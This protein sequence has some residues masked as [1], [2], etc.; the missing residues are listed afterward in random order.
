M[1]MYLELSRPKG[2]VSRWKKVYDRLQLLNNN[3]PM[4]CPKGT[5]SVSDQYLNEP[6]RKEIKEFLKRE[7]VVLLG[8]NASM[9]QEEKKRRWMLPLDVLATPEKKKEVTMHLLA[10]FRKH[11][12]VKAREFDA[13]EELMPARTDIL[14]SHTKNVLVRV[15]ETTACHSYH[16]TSSGLRVASVPTLLQFFLAILYAPKEFLE[17][18]PEQR[19]L[20]AAE[21]LVNS[22]NSSKRKRKAFFP[23]DCLGKQPTMISMRAE[24]SELYKKLSENKNSREFIEMFFQYTPTELTKTQRQKVRQSLK[25]TLRRH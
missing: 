10:M 25:K 1:A 16:K 13:Y 19:F 20:C 5:E 11:E 12:A 9:L 21:H 15:Y 17:A 24:K 6:M 4:V 22:A 14:D 3:Y 18:Q 7:G 2:D 8:F 23:L